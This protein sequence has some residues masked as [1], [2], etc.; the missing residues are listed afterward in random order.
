MSP[1]VPTSITA[2]KTAIPCF[3]GY[4]EKQGRDDL[5]LI[6]KPTV[7]S[8]LTEYEIIFGRSR[9]V[10]VNI[11]LHDDN[12]LNGE[13]VVSQPIFRMYYAIQLFFENG[14]GTCYIISS[15]TCQGA[16]ATPAARLVQM[17]EALIAAGEVD[18]ITLLV[19]PDAS[20][21][22]IHTIISSGNASDLIIK[23]NLYHQLYKDSL[24]QCGALRNRFSI[25]DVWYPL[26]STQ[27]DAEQYITAFRESIG[28]DHLSY[29]GAYYPWIRTTIPCYINEK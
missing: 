18:E 26:N 28:A 8:S 15:A 16:G 5:S 24:A 19:F 6:N 2:V 23:T 29:G 14:G 3:I 21:L 17:Q 13:I 27:S 1:M 22:N 9:S 4:T 25:L 10:R 7:I 12:S 11:H 20:L